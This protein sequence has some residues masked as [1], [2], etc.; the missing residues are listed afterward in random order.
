[1][2]ALHPSRAFTRAPHKR[3]KLGHRI[4]TRKEPVFS[5]QFLLVSFLLAGITWLVFGQTIRH[6]F[7][8]FDD[9]VYVYDNPLIADGVT[10]QGVSEHLTT[11]A[12][13][14]GIST[15]LGTSNASR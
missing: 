14:T 3:N 11:R 8:N 6:D 4:I 13:K 5:N 7:V 12:R 10:L 15:R 1:M 2:A 9:H